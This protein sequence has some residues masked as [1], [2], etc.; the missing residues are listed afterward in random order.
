[1]KKYRVTTILPNGGKNWYDLLVETIEVKDKCYRLFGKYVSEELVDIELQNFYFPIHCT[2][3]QRER[4]LKEISLMIFFTGKIK[5][6]V[7]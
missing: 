4:Y 5:R 6:L 7:D 3:R 1:M 2:I